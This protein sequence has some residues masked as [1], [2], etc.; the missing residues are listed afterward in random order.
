MGGR[1]MLRVAHPAGDGDRAL[2]DLQ[3]VA[4]RVD[5]WAARLTRFTATS[6]L[7]ALNADPGRTVTPVGP[8]LAAILWWARDAADLTDGVVDA[9]MLD[10][11]LAVETGDAP[12]ATVARGQPRWSL[13]Q[14][15]RGAVVARESPFRFDLDGVAKGWI[16]D[17]ALWRLRRYPGALVDADGDVALRVADGSSWLVGVADPRDDGARDL[18]RLRVPHRWV[19]R[20]LGIATSGTA[21]HR[22]APGPDGRERH[23]LLDPRTGGAAIS[24]VVQATVIASSARIAE[25]LAKATVIAGSEDVADLLDRTSHG[26]V[27][28]LTSGEVVATPSLLE[29]MA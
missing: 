23:H 26:A 15:P 6:E 18:V 3:V 5:R 19:G 27:L 20:P 9:T 4:A 7:A 1:L 13:S 29:W 10:E 24:D 12:T 8:T 17:R 2:H 11:R 14:R 21:V 16:A 28:M 25:A 22:W